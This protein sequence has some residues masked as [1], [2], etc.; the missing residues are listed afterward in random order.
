M[1]ISTYDAGADNDGQG[2]HPSRWVYELL[3][4]NFTTCDMFDRA[5]QSKRET[6]FAWQHPHRLVING[7]QSYVT[8]SNR[9]LSSVCLDCHNH[10]IFKMSWD[11]NHAG[12]LCNHQQAS[13][14]LPDNRFP[15]HHLTWV[16]SET[17]PNVYAASTKYYPL[18]ARE[19][20]ICTASPCTFE[21][22][23]EVSEP[24][25]TS[26]IIDLLQD[27][28]TILTNLNTAREKE[29]SRYEGATDDWAVQAPLNL[30]TYLKNLLESEPDQVRSISKRNKRFAVLFGPRC[31]SIFH[32]LE[33]EDIVIEREGLDE[34]NFK[35]PAP[36]PPKGPF[37]TTEVDTYRSFLEDV[38]SEVQC[39]IH[40]AGQSAEQPT[41]C[42]PNLYADL[43]A[44]EVLNAASN[45]L[46]NT[47]PYR[48]L[49]VL[50]AQSREMVANAYKRQW[51]RLP[52]QRRQLVD[53]LMAVAN[54]SGDDQLSE[55]AITQSS[56]FDSQTQT[57]TKEDDDGVVSQA[58][59]YLGLQPPNNHSA[60]VVLQ[61]FR[62]KIAASPGDA[63]SARSM[64]QLIAN[65]STDD[66]Y[67]VK[68]V[69]ETDDS[70]MTFETARVVLGL[71]VSSLSGP[72][73]IDKCRAKV[74]HLV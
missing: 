56:V 29:P 24:R 21:L 19:F 2:C 8:E 13:W 4:N 73:L 16:G 45:S 38:R 55:F 3:H 44:Q 25:L 52:S 71:D 5:R 22:T 35:P 60:D 58:L 42:T 6:P 14:P 11:S 67:Q 62:T 68:L 30:N 47:E 10:L 70:R 63:A 66:N 17:D 34:G 54:H 26:W 49:G 27:Q 57:G 41:F 37:G 51:D 46:V 7:N 69:M 40:K 72:D 53:A 61:A 23:L 18:I 1:W 20:F 9:V 48:I 43:G 50:P 36:D 31:F 33:F 64:L 59:A 65:N 12:S 28:A 15:W 74:G 39:L 32:H